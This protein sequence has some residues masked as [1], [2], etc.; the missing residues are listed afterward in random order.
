M[1]MKSG[2]AYSMLVSSRSCD[3]III[4]S[5]RSIVPIVMVPV[6]P[7]LVCRAIAPVASWI[8][9]TSGVSGG[10]CSISPSTMA[11]SSGGKSGLNGG[12]NG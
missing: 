11:A 3:L 10:S 6:S 9:W 12:G 7:I 1:L 4:L 8:Y 5:V 2:C